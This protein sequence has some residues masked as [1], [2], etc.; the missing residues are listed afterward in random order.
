MD[1][2]SGKSPQTFG[3]AE[4]VGSVKHNLF[5][6]PIVIFTQG[7]NIVTVQFFKVVH[8][9]GWSQQ[10]KKEKHGGR[11]CFHALWTPE[12]DGFIHCFPPVENH[13]KETETGKKKYDKVFRPEI[14]KPGH[15]PGKRGEKVDSVSPL[16]LHCVKEKVEEAVAADY[17]KDHQ[18][19]AGH[20]SNRS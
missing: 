6:R 1:Y 11:N 15:F 19:A 3:P 13:K 10:V 5:S 12:W 17:G 18:G 16:D 4:I 9:Q 14:I 8:K 2:F 20:Q 7:V